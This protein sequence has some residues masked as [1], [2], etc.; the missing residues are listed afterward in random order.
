MIAKKHE[1]LRKG[2]KPEVDILSV[3][4]QSGGFSDENLVDQLMTF[5]AAGHETTASRSVLH[6][7][8]LSSQTDDYSRFSMQWALYVLCKHPEIQ[9]KLRA[10]I[11]KKISSLDR[12]IVASDIDDCHYLQAVCSEVLRLWSPVPLTLRVAAVN[13]SISGHFIPKGTTVIM[14]PAATNTS[15]ELWGSDALEFKPERFLGADGK[16]NN[17]GGAT[18]NYAFLSKSSVDD[19]AEEQVLTFPAFLHGPRSCIGQ[20]F[21]QAEFACILAAWVGSFETTF[22]EGSPLIDGEVEIKGGVTTKPA[23]GLWCKAQSVPGW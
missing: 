22:E 20:K 14:A 12:D 9:S 7:F 21:A 6:F 15:K 23:G 8:P 10:E 19:K 2:E 18:S 16:A 13:T 11:R 3:A 5:L 17:Q 4:L 1:T